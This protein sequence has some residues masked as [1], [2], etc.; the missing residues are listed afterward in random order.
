MRDGDGVRGEE[1]K[2]EGDDIDIHLIPPG[3]YPSV[4]ANSSAFER[5]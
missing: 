1:E 5:V 4:R 3:V 2:E